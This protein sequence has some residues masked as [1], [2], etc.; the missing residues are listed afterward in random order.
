MS[1]STVTL[2]LS[3]TDCWPD[4]GEPGRPAEEVL[5]YN[6][7]SGYIP[8]RTHALLSGTGNASYTVGG[9]GK[10]YKAYSGTLHF[11]HWVTHTNPTSGK[12]VVAAT[13]GLWQKARHPLTPLA[14]ARPTPSH[15]LDSLTGH[16]VND[17]AAHAMALLVGARAQIIGSSVNLDAL[18]FTPSAEGNAI[19]RTLGIK[20]LKDVKPE[21]EGS[22]RLCWRPE[23]LACLGGK[24][25]RWETVN[26]IG[27]SRGGVV[28]IAVA[29]LIALYL[30]HI[31]VNII[32]LDP[33]PGTGDW[34]ENMCTLPGAV[35]GNYLGIYAIDE[36][37]IG[38]NGVIPRVLTTKGTRWDPLKQTLTTSGLRPEQYQLIFSRGRHS[39]IPGARTLLG[40]KYHRSKDGKE[41]ISED[42]GAVGDLI[43]HLCQHRLSGWGVPCAQQEVSKQK[44]ELLKKTINTNSKLFYAMRSTTYTATGTVAGYERARGVSSSSGRSNTKLGGWD[45][46]LEE[47]DLSS[48]ADL[49]AENRWS[50]LEIYLPRRTPDYQ[51]LRPDV[52]PGNN[53]TEADH[54]PWQALTSLPDSEFGV[55]GGSTGN[56]SRRY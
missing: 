28:A 40:D 5:N 27:H 55:R 41:N 51:G 17:L 45:A 56:R 3:G 13:K 35:L 20:P 8:S 6:P 44:V 32:A 12:K 33:V 49:H 36:T 50:Y 24:A 26:L 53:P 14:I 9:C 16:S 42:V 54:A 23:D 34:P 22:V 46:L 52:A 1:N 19:A 31:K 43:F 11:D 15:S 38:F 47:P 10:V 18:H 30:P 39:T 7:L 21:I 48:L 29:N 4:H 37:S 2:C 25:H